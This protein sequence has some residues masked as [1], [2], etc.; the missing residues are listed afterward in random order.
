MYEKIAQ[1]LRERE[2]RFSDLSRGTGIRLS[3]FTEM[4]RR[5]GSCLSLRHAKAVADYFGV[6]I[7]DLLEEDR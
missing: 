3:V 2:E 5:P 4:K 7:E 1:F 6:K